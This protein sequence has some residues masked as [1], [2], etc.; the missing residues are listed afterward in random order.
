[1]AQIN[2]RTMR[3]PRETERIWNNRIVDKNLEDG[4]LES[5]NSLKVFELISIC[6]GQ[7]NGRGPFSNRPHIN[8]RIR[9][10]HIP[11][12]ATH[13]DEIATNLQKKL[14]E[15]FGNENTNADIEYKIKFNSSRFKQEIMR[16]FVVHV[17]SRAV[18]EELDEIDPSIKKWFTEN[19]NAVCQL[20]LFMGELNA[21]R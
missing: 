9:E 19:I 4:W 7:A 14:I 6:E 11:M 16:D 21:L 10:K 5:L 15:L 1:M 20:D 18:I 3:T 8:L 13:F 17:Q 2:R 12:M